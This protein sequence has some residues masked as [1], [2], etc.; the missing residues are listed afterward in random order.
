MTR[1]HGFCRKVDWHGN[2]QLGDGNGRNRDAFSSGVC[3]DFRRL[4]GKNGYRDF[5]A[6]TMPSRRIV[7]GRQ[8]KLLRVLKDSG[9]LVND[10]IDDAIVN[11]LGKVHVGNVIYEGRNCDS[12]QV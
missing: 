6:R 4:W 8:R 7:E 9:Q 3:L 11:N 10:R 5:S 1:H 12:D 2:G